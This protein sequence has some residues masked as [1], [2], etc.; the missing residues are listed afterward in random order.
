MRLKI[1]AKI[2][3]S[4]EVTNLPSYWG[5]PQDFYEFDVVKS[6]FLVIP[7]LLVTLRFALPVRKGISKKNAESQSCA[8][9]LIEADT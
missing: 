8:F 4:I 5:L 6:C 2:S 1:Q 3:A 7:G 9:G